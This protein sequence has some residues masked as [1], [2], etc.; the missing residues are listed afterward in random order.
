VRNY[1]ELEGA[2]ST[3]AAQAAAKLRNQGEVAG[4]VMTFLYT[5]K[6]AEVQGGGSQ[7]V[8]LHPPS[9]DT[10]DIISAALQALEQVYDP[11]FAYKKAGVCLLDLR[12]VEQL[13][14]GADPEKLE[15][16][17]NLMKSVD[18]INARFGTRLV[19]HASEHIESQGWRS[20]REMRSQ[21]YTTSWHELRTVKA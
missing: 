14:F 18:E 16:R 9:A 2:V 12:T 6:H 15:R 5:G 7:V 19:R 21:A 1:Y 8:K 10:G 13:A 20:K 4:A 3:F 17:T 11:D